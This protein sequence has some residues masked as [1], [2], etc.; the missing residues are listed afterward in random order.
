LKVKLKEGVGKSKVRVIKF[1]TLGGQGVKHLITLND[2]KCV[3]EGLNNGSA[4]LLDLL[5]EH[6]GHKVYYR[7]RPEHDDQVLVVPPSINDESQ[8]FNCDGLIYTMHLA[9]RRKRTWHPAILASNTGDCPHIFFHADYRTREH[10]PVRLVG[11]VHSGWRGCAKNIIGKAIRRVENLLCP[12][13]NLRIG[14][15]G[16]ICTKCYEVDEA[17]WKNLV[18]YHRHLHR[19]KDKKHWML[20]MRGIINQQLVQAGIKPW[21]I[22]T[23]MLCSHC[24][25]EQN[26]KHVLFS[27]RRGEP[28]RNGLFIC[29]LAD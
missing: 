17:V 22:E 3:K 9:P 21:Q 19:G 12:L 23:S 10:D 6:F 25:R 7:I 2:V 4:V 18:P 16:G 24:Q 26:G 29:A 28:H 15:W 5:E 14:F 11:L 13:G 1:S 8:D 27:H 20:D